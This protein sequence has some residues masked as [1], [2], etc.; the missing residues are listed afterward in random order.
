[1]Y[2]TAI[3]TVVGSAIG[4]VMA[5]GASETGPG[6]QVYGGNGGGAGVSGGGSGP[7]GASGTG[8]S[9]VGA[10][11]GVG[12]GINVDSGSSGSGN[13]PD[14]ACDSISQGVQTE[15]IPVDIMWAID[16]S[17]SMREEAVAVQENVNAFS[18][19][20]TAAGIDVHVGMMAAYP[21]IA[22]L[23]GTP[24]ICGGIGICVPPPLGMG[25]VQCAGND[26][27]PPNFFHHQGGIIGSRDAA[28]IFIN[29]FPEYRQIFRPN[30]LKYLVIVTD[31]DSTGGQAGAYADNPD[32]FIADYTALDPMMR[33][34]NGAPKWK[35]SGIY[36]YSECQN[37]SAIGNFW[38]SVIEKT[39]GVPGDI[40]SC[41]SGQ[42][43]ACTQTF[44]T[45]FDSLAKTIVTAAKPLDCEYT[46]PAAPAGKT[47]DK[48][49]V[50]V[51]LESNGMKE[52]IGWVQDASACHP[53]L[54]GW[55]YD[56][57]DMPTRILTCP[58]SCDKIKGTTNGSVSVAF[59]CARK[60]VPIAQ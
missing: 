58:K 48:E 57:N 50:N 4:L 49:K 54:G 39:G 42:Q 43:A 22:L 5:C 17:G 31:D 38:K 2:K 44:K 55:F 21:C 9:G 27:K 36:A 8:S 16:T 34:A 13:N 20:I 24:P 40:C 53:E 3:I 32:K 45:V 6:S 35:M 7:G 59:G 47:F 52:N 10:L 12:G 11:G 30:S 46:I 37:A 41:P 15:K 23:P 18:Q 33:D 19:Q 51:D 25:Q 29:L 60:P 28:A 14:A 26:S 56:S 1:M